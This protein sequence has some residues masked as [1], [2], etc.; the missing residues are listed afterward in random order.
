MIEGTSTGVSPPQK[1]AARVQKQ[2][3][4][5]EVSKQTNPSANGTDQASATAGL[6]ANLARRFAEFNHTL[7]SL[8]DGQLLLSSPVF[9]GV[10]PRMLPDLRSALLVLKQWE[11]R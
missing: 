6:T 3:P 4:Q 5:A 10:R 8:P 11:G 1:E 9:A 7:L 2:E